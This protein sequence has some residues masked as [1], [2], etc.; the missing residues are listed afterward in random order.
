MTNTN[1]CTLCGRA[2][3]SG[4][5]IP[6]DD[7]FLCPDCLDENTV[8]CSHC[9]DRIWSRDNVGSDDTP[10]AR[11]AMT[12]TSLPANAAEPSSAKTRPITKGR[13]MTPRT[14]MTATSAAVES[15]PS[16]TITSNRSPSSTEMGFVILE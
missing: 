11:P 13:T 15:V 14:A 7:H 12:G 5:L 10:C 9:G 1:I 2:L 6:L 16:M 3:P 4:H 8:I